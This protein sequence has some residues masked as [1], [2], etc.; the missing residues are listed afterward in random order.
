[1]KPV[2]NLDEFDN[3]QENNNGPY[4]EK[5]TPVSEKIGARNLSYSVSVV[6]PGKKICPFHSHRIIEGCRR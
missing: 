6:P 4:Q 2:I 5:Y 1:M 3:Y